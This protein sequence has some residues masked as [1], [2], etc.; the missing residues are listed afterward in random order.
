MAEQRELEGGSNKWKDKY[1]NALDAQ[2]KQEKHFSLQQSLL[3][4]AMLRVSLAAE[5]QATELDDSLEAL[6]QHLRD[7]NQVEVSRDLNKLDIVLKD[8]EQNREQAAGEVKLALEQ[9]V[10][11]LARRELSRDIKKQLND[12]LREFTKRRQ[13]IQDYP[14]LL[15]KLAELQRLVLLDSNEEAPGNTEGGFFST[16]L[17]KKSSNEKEGKNKASSNEPE[18]KPESGMSDRALF[19]LNPHAA[20]KDSATVSA[21]LRSIINALLQSVEAQAVSS[22]RVLAV[23]KKLKQGITNADLIPVLNEVCELVMAAYVAATGAFV[24]YLNNVNHDLVDIYKVVGGAA[25]R[26]ASLKNAS[27]LMQSQMLENFLGL[28]NETEKATNLSELKDTVQLRIN[29]IRLALDEYQQTVSQDETASLQL[30]ELAAQIKT[31]ESE[32]Q[33]NQE[34]LKQQRYKA[35]HD[36][37]T[38]LPNRESYNERVALESK[39]WQ[40]YG[41]PLTLAIC[42]LDHFKKINDTLGHQAGDRVLQVIS[43]AISRRLRDVDFFGRYGGE[44][45]IVILPDTNAEQAFIVLDKLRAAIA[46]TEFNYKDTPVSISMSIG[47]SEFKENDTEKEVVERADKSLYNAKSSGRNQ[48]MVG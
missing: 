20:V 48:C 25:T 47:L 19:E 28:E 13:Q 36:P 3:T 30:S 37:L 22:E 8:F 43:Q 5:G 31:M 29:N 7:N 23:Q 24:N 6:R 17:G 11:P 42:D 32:A 33:K 1:L 2:E 38:K 39:R 9:I 16:L 44:E 21:Q 27:E 34:I 12:F 15:K 46:K 14:N 41:H 18:L 10:E 4:R 35:M 26:E 40:R 45:F